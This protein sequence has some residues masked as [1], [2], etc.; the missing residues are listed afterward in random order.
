MKSI[1]RLD[2][3]KDKSV[4]K[5]H[6]AGMTQAQ[7]ANHCEV[8][9]SSV[10]RI[11]RSNKLTEGLNKI[12]GYEDAVKFY[13]QGRTRIEIRRSSH[14]SMETIRCIERKYCAEKKRRL[15]AERDN[16]ARRV[17]EERIERRRYREEI[18]QDAEKRKAENAANRKSRQ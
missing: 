4:I 9:Q 7:I 17:I 3:E 16:K 12:P 1:P 8:S 15:D 18:R 13:L 6:L 2:S 10:C 5:A 14:V 11:L